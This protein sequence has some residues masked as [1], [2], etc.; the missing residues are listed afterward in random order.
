MSHFLV[1][2]QTL[3]EVVTDLT[4]PIY[5]SFITLYSTTFVHEAIIV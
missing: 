2:M 4:P 3:D 1:K 5:D